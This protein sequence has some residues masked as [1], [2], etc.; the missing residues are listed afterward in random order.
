MVYRV[1]ARRLR[2][3]S[4]SALLGQEEVVQTLKN[5]LKSGKI[6]SAYLFYG[7]RGTGKTTVARIFA[8][9]LNC[10][11][12]ITPEPCQ[13]CPSCIEIKEGNSLDVHEIDGATYTQ[14]DKIREIKEMVYFQ[15]AR[16]RY[17]IYI[18]DEVHMLSQSAFNAIL[19]LLE[20]PPPHAIFIFATTEKHKIPATII[21]RC[22]VFNFHLFPTE[23]IAEYLKK[24]ILEEGILAEESSLL[25]ISKKAK[26]SIRDGLSILDQVIA[27]SGEK[28]DENLVSK[29]LGETDFELL[30]GLARFIL[31]GN[32][33]EVLKIMEEV[34]R[35]GED[36]FYFYNCLM[37]F[38]RY[39]LKAKL[40]ER[41]TSLSESE[42]EQ[43]LKISSSA[44]Y[45]ELLR[46]Y[47][48]VVENQG[49]VN[50]SEY[51]YVSVELIMLK[52]C[53]LPKLEKIENLLSGTEKPLPKKEIPEVKQKSFKER[54]TDE[55]EKKSKPL[56]GYLQDAYIKEEDKKIVITFK[57]NL[58]KGYERCLEK[59]NL[60]LIKEK[61]KEILGTEYEIT[62]VL[63]EEKE[64]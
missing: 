62:L 15:P 9:A 56:A 30:S 40:G 36:L 48:F 34:L 25:K 23:E 18:I 8:K 24:V 1:L 4:F 20:E 52:L 17:K 13:E 32:A 39:S 59:E 63:E 21:S 6:G 41:E 37:D 43:V 12:G 64:K 42:W 2:P 28:I 57:S 35:S 5:A 16:D 7:P 22:Q 11:K 38:L 10:H 54:L 55:I 14:V 47:S 51:P 45:E 27:L 58:K 46:C 61:I 44:T 31:E 33:K 3:Q 29:L 49:L 26:G 60:A 53:E 50:R 19:K